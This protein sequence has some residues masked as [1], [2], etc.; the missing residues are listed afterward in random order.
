M[1]EPPTLGDPD[2]VFELYDSIP[3]PVP[4]VLTSDIVEEVASKLSGAAGPGGTDSEELKTWLL[5]YGPESLALRTKMAEFANWLANKHPPWAAYRALMACRLVALDKQPGVRP[6]GI[7]KIYRQ[8]MAKCLL[9]VSGHHT[10]QA[11]GNFNLCAGLR[12][13][14]EGVAHVV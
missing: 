1:W 6:L 3:Q 4:I 7:S 8:L 10:T 5:R 9:A 2:G 11:C 12:A 14:I 13:G